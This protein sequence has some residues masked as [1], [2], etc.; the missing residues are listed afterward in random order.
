VWILGAYLL[1]VGLAWQQISVGIVIAIVLLGYSF[2]WYERH[3]KKE[4]GICQKKQWFWFLPV[5]LMLG[6]VIMEDQSR[7][8]K[9]YYAFE[10]EVPCELTGRIKMVVQ[11]QQG[12]A[13]YVVNNHISLSEDEQYL[14]ENVI[15]YTSDSQNYRIGNQITVQ[16]SLQKFKKAT[17]PGQ[18]HEDKYYKTLNID[19]KLQAE[20]IVISD[21]DYSRYAQSLSEIKSKLMK[22][23]QNIL[24]DREAGTLTAMLLGEKYLLEE[25]V[26]Q[27]YQDNGISHILAISGLH[28]SLI[29]MSVFWLLR[30]CKITKLTATLITVFFLYS[31]GVMTNFSVSTNRS[32]V[33]MAV[34]LIAALVGKTY[35]MIT[36]T[37]LSALIIL[38]QNPYQLMSAG[39]LLSFLAVIGIAVLL[40]ILKELF[41]GKNG[42]KDGLLISCCAMVTTT[43]IV[44][45]YFYQYPLYG[46]LTN[47][48][49]LPFMTV[50]TLTALLAGLL[51]ILSAKIGVF[52]IGGANYILKLYDLVC[53]GIRRL[54]FYVINVGDPGIIRILFSFILIVL[55]VW[56]IRKYPKKYM[57]LLLLL[58]QL[59]LF[60]PSYARGLRITMLDVG[61][62]DAIYIES[63]EGTSFLIDGGSANLGKVGTYRIVP[64]LK[65]RG[66]GKLDYAIITHMDQDH[67]SGLSEML[68]QD[69][70]PV[71]CV[72]LP[73]LRHKE[74]NY[75]ELE[76]LAK[77]KE[78]PLR[79]IKAGDYIKEG[80]LEIYCLNPTQEEVGSTSNAASTVLSV[81]Y[82]E[83]DM[84]L[85]GDLEKEGEERLIQRLKDQSYLKSWGIT[86]AND[87][88]VLKVAHHGSKYSTSEELLDLIIP[89]YALISCGENNWYGHPHPEL[90]ER[91]RESGC[92]TFI[93]YEKGALLLQTDGNLIEFKSMLEQ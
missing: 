61:Q 26:K 28:V 13:L 56:L 67:I 47:L 60:L 85:T 33:M 81:T 9:L 7:L 15:V 79:Y 5:I 51:G 91:L 22:V 16:G 23:Y 82:G 41:P 27:L 71:E 70:F 30:K 19:F 8:P 66:I 65:S 86:P 90:L 69:L 89:E 83:F 1:G 77:E 73:D 11:K 64:F 39:F 32:V 36:A 68:E 25:D 59:I 3:H 75:L 2:L 48:I 92:E 80:M 74:E 55:F 29:G 52:M 18:F 42:I 88:D 63:K 43:P 46:I 54:P 84:L 37:A 12:Q 10:E 53:E 21:S 35:D 17:N 76:S 31:Y 20:Q 72:V 50:L 49:I 58:S 57:V 38:I 78:I 4:M 44:L 45:L 14:T 87:Y 34:L 93:T 24:A 6:F 40:P 62:G